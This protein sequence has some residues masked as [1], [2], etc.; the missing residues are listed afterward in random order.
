M[1]EGKPGGGSHAGGDLMDRGPATK[2]AAVQFGDFV[3][4]ASARRLYEHNP[5]IALNPKALDVL[6]YLIEHPR[7]ILSKEELLKEVWGEVSVT[8]DALVQRVL[9]V[10][11][12][13][14]DQAR[15]PQFVRTHARRGYE[16][17]AEPAGAVAD[18]GNARCGGSDRNVLGPDMNMS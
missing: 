8:D 17:I 3:F 7:R 13:L 10:R 4:D 2:S 14:R 1:L 15:N 5:E 12:A 16:W 6:A 18:T 11:K 9:D